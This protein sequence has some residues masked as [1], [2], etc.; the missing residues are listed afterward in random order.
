VPYARVR[1]GRKPPTGKHFPAETVKTLVFPILMCYTHFAFGL[2]KG[3]PDTDSTQKKEGFIERVDIV[4]LSH[5]ISFFRPRRT[6]AIAIK[7]PGK[8]LWREGGN[9]HPLFLIVFETL[10]KAVLL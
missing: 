3:F 7:R 6:Q 8:S 10:C 1:D 4:F 9:C 5:M 2:A